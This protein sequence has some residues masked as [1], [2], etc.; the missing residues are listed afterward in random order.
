MDS[1][2]SM[3]YT[4]WGLH[5]YLPEIQIGYFGQEVKNCLVVDEYWKSSFHKNTHI[6]LA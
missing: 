2:F 1:C 3:S 5:E 4:L 6:E